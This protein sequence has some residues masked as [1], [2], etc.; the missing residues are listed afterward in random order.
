MKRRILFLA[1]T[2]LVGIECFSQIIFENGYFI[3]DSNH[4]IECLIKNSEWKNNP[5]E[6]EYKLSE[7]TISQKLSFE[8]VKEFGINGV[9]KYITAIVKIDRSGNEIDK[10][11]SEKEPSFKEERLSLKVLVEGKASL[12][13][14]EEGSLIRYFYSLNDPEIKQ[15]VYKR[16][17]IDNNIVHNNSFKQ[18]LFRDLKCQAIELNEVQQLSY[19]QIPLERIFIKYNECINSHYV[20][21]K[22]NQKKDVFNLS[23]RPGLNYSNL[24]LKGFRNIDFNNKFSSRF[25]I[26]VE[27]ILPYN[28]NKWGVIIEPTYQYFKSEKATETKHVSGGILI[29]KVNYQSIELP[30]GIRHYFFLNDQ[31]KIFAD[32]SYLLDFYVNS[33]IKNTR[34]DGTEVESLEIKSGRN[35]GFGIGYKFKNKY[36]L[37]MRYLTKREILGDYKILNSGYQ[38]FSVILGYALF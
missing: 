19:N 31:S 32:L 38:T 13:L 7:D 17:L 36:S 28:K 34:T 4:R 22:S 11:D 16:F 27:F 23:L 29:S 25:G 30:I 8:N 21:Y 24:Q 12:F 5:S 26:E 10:M 20:H 1:L 37:E 35:L 6:F 9:A 2:M 33:L 18:Q 14:Y 3:N 15:L